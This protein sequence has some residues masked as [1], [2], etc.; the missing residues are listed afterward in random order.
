VVYNNFSSLNADATVSSLCFRQ[1]YYEYLRYTVWNDEGL[2]GDDSGKLEIFFE[3]ACSLINLE[4]KV[5]DGKLT[6]EGLIPL[7]H[8]ILPGPMLK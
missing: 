8:L 1:S 6:P 4:L 2:H 5:F 7:L 3:I